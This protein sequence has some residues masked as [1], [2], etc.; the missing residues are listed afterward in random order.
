MIRTDLFIPLKMTALSFCHAAGTMR[1]ER[2]ERD[3]SKSLAIGYEPERDR[4]TWDGW[5]IHCGQG[6][7]V[8]LPDQLGGGVPRLPRGGGFLR[9]FSGGKSVVHGLHVCPAAE[10]ISS[11]RENEALSGGGAVLRNLDSGSF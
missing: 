2:R 3:G 11:E 5:D 6:L 10:W 4:L 1:T 8:L 9:L 7:D